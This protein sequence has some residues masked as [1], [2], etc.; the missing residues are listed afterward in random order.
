MAEQANGFFSIAEYD[1]KSTQLLQAIH[2]GQEEKACMCIGKEVDVN[3]RFHNGRTLLMLAAEKDQS[4]VVDALIAVG[5]DV[6][7]DVDSR[8]TTLMLAAEKG[9]KS[10]L[11]ILID[12]GAE[13]NRKDQNGRT[14]LMLAAEG[15]HSE[16]VDVLLEAGAEIH[17]QSASNK[18]T[19]LTLVREE[20]VLLRLI[21]SSAQLISRTRHLT[22]EDIRNQLEKER[23]KD[24]LRN[25]LKVI[26]SEFLDEQLTSAE[27]AEMEEGL[28]Q[29]PVFKSI[30]EMLLKSA[31]YDVRQVHHTE[32][33]YL[34]MQIGTFNTAESL[35]FILVKAG[36]KCM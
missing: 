20:R 9:H 4:K 22:E 33:R 36:D 11:G 26:E 8:K 6:N 24:D 28:E 5:A 23:S 3:K 34:V 12:N 7:A 29:I 16:A 19:A 17:I 27:R 21:Q 25:V 32:T 18:E 14:A 35:N 13:L 1:V 2:N 10:I 15:G 30:R 31:G